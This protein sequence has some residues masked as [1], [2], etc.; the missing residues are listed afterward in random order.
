LTDLGYEGN[1][2]WEHTLEQV[3]ETF[4]GENYPNKDP[5]NNDD[6][7]VMYISETEHYWMDHDCT[8]I[9]LNDD[10]ANDIAPLCQYGGGPLPTTTAQQTTTAFKCPELYY[11]FDGHCYFAYLVDDVT[12]DWVHADDECKNQGGHLVSI[13]SQAED[14]W[15]KDLV[16][17][18]DGQEHSYWIGGYFQD[19]QWLWVDKSEFEYSNFI[20]T[21]Q[22]VAGE[23]IYQRWYEYEDGWTTISCQGQLFG[24]VCKI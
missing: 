22:P 24:F 17:A 4:W 5:V 20:G 14:D 11:P 18:L 3:S 12:F 10:Y 8:E 9:M 6:C 7:G 15:I 23:C 1:W 19:N 2:H 16:K 21:Y 13:N